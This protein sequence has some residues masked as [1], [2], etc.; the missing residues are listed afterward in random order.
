[1]RPDCAVL[2][3]AEPGDDI[4]A[5]L[6]GLADEL[7]VKATAPLPR[8]PAGP[9]EETL[10]RGPLTDDAIARIVARLMP[11]NAIVCNEAVTSGRRFV[12][13]TQQAPPHDYLQLTGGAIGIGIPLAAGAAIA[14]PGRKVIGLQADGS[15]MYT[16]Q[17]L[18]TQARE[19][20]DVVTIIFANR[21]Y[22]ILQGE[23]LAVGVGSI[24]RNAR[25]M[26]SLDEPALDWVAMAKGMGV[27]AGA[28]GRCRA[29]R[30][31]VRRG[32][33]PAR[34]VPH[35]GF[36]GAAGAA[37]LTAARALP[38]PGA[39]RERHRSRPIGGSR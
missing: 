24:G 8:P 14:C 20:L 33:S 18:W 13:L 30:Q 5:A 3:L 19:G 21:A 38:G 15:G 39:W 23:M 25:R 27:E 26:L 32:H 12:G 10:P 7:G 34:A 6:A 17:G 4:A 2:T 37:V 16:L 9:D 29:I 35:R 1:M 11:E 22:A 31:A 28:G 36:D